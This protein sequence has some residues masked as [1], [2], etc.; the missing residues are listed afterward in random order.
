[1]TLLPA[2]QPIVYGLTSEVLAYEALARWR[3]DGKILG[4]TDL[5]EAPQWSGVDIDMLSAILDRAETVSGIAPRLF[6]NVSASTISEPGRLATWISHLAKITSYATFAVVIEIT[7]GIGDDKLQEAWP[8]LKRL[9]VKLALDDFG[10]G[11]SS[12]ARL[13]RY[14][15]DYCKFEGHTVR[16]HRIQEAIRYCQNSGILPI[17]ERVEHQK[18]SEEFADMGLH[19]QQGFLHGRPVLVD[20]LAERTGNVVI[21]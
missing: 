13:V 17:V 1:M 6:I 10:D 14:D 8:Q 16:D 3:R 5:P 9:G 18:S 11:R 20:N 12:R 7:E 2:L 21:A 15:W 4:P 19:W